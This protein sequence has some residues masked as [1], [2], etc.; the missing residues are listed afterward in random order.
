MWI[1]TPLDQHCVPSRA[2]SGG[3]CLSGFKCSNPRVFLGRHIGNGRT[4]GFWDQDSNSNIDY[5]TTDV[6]KGCTGLLRQAYWFRFTLTWQ[7][8][9]PVCRNY[10]YILKW[11]NLIDVF[12]CQWSSG[13]IQGQFIKPWTGPR[14]V[15][16]TQSL[17]S[18]GHPPFSISAVCLDINV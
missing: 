7:P 15:C 11:I 6:V 14:S 1:I 5:L 10:K 17:L 8:S 12:S 3:R 9:Y 2:P 16:G 13:C 4:K 18:I